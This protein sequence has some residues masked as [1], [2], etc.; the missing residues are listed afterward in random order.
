MTAGPS[1]VLAARRSIRSAHALSKYIVI[2]AALLAVPAAAFA[3]TDEIQVY[4]GSIAEPGVINLMLHNNYTPDGQKS[5]A[6]PGGLIPDKSY[7]GVAEW[8]F[9]VTP[10][11]EAGVYLPLYSI[12]KDR[13]AT[14]DG[15]KLRLLFAEPHAAERTFVYAV[16]FELSFNADCWDPK[17]ITSEIR[18]ILGWHVHSWDF[19]VNPI[20]DTD[21]TGGFANLD[22]APA[23]RIAYNFRPKWALSVEEYADLGPL[24]NFYSGDQQSHQLWAVF[25]HTAKWADIEAGIGFGLTPGSDRVTIKLMLSRDIHR[26]GKH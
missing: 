7:N 22:F 21:Y 19:L 4:D 15:G 17:R 3:Q 6:F 13:G 18:P 9:G 1:P 25:D 10:W 14:F 24:N 11:F 8:A 12:S 2:A 26:P 5:P 16:N 20:L 23:S